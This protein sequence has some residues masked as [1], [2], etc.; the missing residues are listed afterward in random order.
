MN[1]FQSFQV[2]P[3]PFHCSFDHVLV[4]GDSAL[5][6][7]NGSIMKIIAKL[8]IAT[9]VILGIW[10]YNRI[11]KEEILPTVEKSEI[12]IF[13]N[14]KKIYVRA[15]VWG[16]AGNREEI[17]SLPLLASPPTNFVQPELLFFTLYCLPH[18]QYN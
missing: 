8:M 11:S 7:R 4:P 6:R 14:G 1:E 13:S 17:P 10:F 2:S 9:I 18:Q 15:K 5:A 3:S 16:V 12:L